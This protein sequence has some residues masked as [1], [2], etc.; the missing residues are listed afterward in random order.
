MGKS[1]LKNCLKCFELTISKTG[2]IFPAKY[3]QISIQIIR[4]IR[5]IVLNNEFDIDRLF[6]QADLNRNG[7]LDLK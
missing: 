3:S 6:K 7:T 4:D 2:R 5:H 1:A